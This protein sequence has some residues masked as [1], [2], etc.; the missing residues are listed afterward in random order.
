LTRYIAAEYNRLANKEAIVDLA[1]Q[2]VLI[3]G[4]SRG[5]GRPFAQALLVAGARVAITGRSAAE[6]HE[7]A[8]Q[9]SSAAN[10]V[11][12][13]PADATDPQGAPIES[14]LRRTKQGGEMVMRSPIQA[15]YRF[16]LWLR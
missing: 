16:R 2:V 14:G 10:R 8:T 5:L 11:L 15:V 12:A 4:G 6:L 3:T 9:L 7:T 1:G 13:I